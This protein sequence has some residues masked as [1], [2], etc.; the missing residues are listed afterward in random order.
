MRPTIRRRIPAK[1]WF[2]NYSIRNHENKDS[3][4]RQEMD[5]RTSDPYLTSAT[6]CY[7]GTDHNQQEQEPLFKRPLHGQPQ[8]H[9]LLYHGGFQ[10]RGGGSLRGVPGTF[11]HSLGKDSVSEASSAVSGPI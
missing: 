4:A 5:L 8:T 10:S 3:T 6:V 11:R 2:T 1:I 9:G 7:P